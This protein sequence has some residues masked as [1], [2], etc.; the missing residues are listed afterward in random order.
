MYI[1]ADGSID[2]YLTLHDEELILDH[3]KVSGSILGQYSLIM[4]RNI[5]YSARST[6]E[7]N[8]LVINLDA[9]NQARADNR[10]L[11][12]IIKKMIE[13]MNSN[14][15]M[16]MLDYTVV[17]K[18]INEREEF[19]PRQVFI[20]AFEKWRKVFKYSRKKAFKF[21]DLVEFV[22]KNKV[23]DLEQKKA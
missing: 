6:L 5:N 2:T 11:N 4:Q 14:Q 7:T 1:L 8:M 10:E 3:L 22:N 13:H 16:P 21:S 19:N 17:R 15:A 20:D 23:S 9:L 18:K 12:Q